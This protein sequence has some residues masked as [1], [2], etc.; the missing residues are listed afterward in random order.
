MGDVAEGGAYNWE[1]VIN[2]GVWT[3]TDNLAHNNDCGLRVWQNSTRNH[4]IENFVSYYNKMGMFHGAYANSYTY[5][6]GFFYGCGM[7]L[8]AASTN[9]NRVR[10]ENF[11]IDGAGITDFGIEVIHSPLPGAVPVFVRNTTIRNCKIAAVQDSS[12]PEVHSTDL[13]QCTISGALIVTSNAASGET[14]R[15][16]PTSG[17]CYKITKSGKTNIT[18][19]AAT[20]WGTG[21]GLKAEYFNSNN[22]TNLALTRIDSNISFSEWSTGVHYAIKSSTY[23]IRWTGKI[24]PQYS[25]SY[26]FNLNSGGGHRLWINGKLLLDSW[27]ERYPDTY[28]TPAIALQAGTLYDIK[29]EYFNTD[30]KTG[31]GL[32]WSSPSQQLEYVPQS[33]LYAS[34]IV[35][36]PPPPPPPTTG[37]QLPVANAGEDKIITLPKNYVRL[38]GA[39]SVDP[40]GW[41]AAGSWSK[42]SGPSCNLRE[43][44]LLSTYA[45]DLVAGTYVFRLKVTDSKGATDTDDMTV[46]VKPAT[47][48]SSSAT[49]AVG[50][51]IVITAPASTVTLNAQA[52]TG[53]DGANKY[54]W[55]KVSGPTEYNIENL[56]Q[57]P[58]W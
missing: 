11:T 22:L 55:K 4:V 39:L 46:I 52:Y 23:S 38:S 12:S 57:P 1:A 37:N 10:I 6:G 2:E 49:L 34:A 7:Q 20:L 58:R 25:E 14:I 16:Q 9:T 19:F 26:I 13:V 53:D 27:N 36:A 48:L 28:K 35:T 18:P 47:T 50:N 54:S 30:A 41:I 29:L 33:Q 31:M 3:F 5:N 40:D 51:D 44:N 15:V 42:V 43:T 45:V 21:K 56:I 17:Q 32:Y 24:Q 8:K